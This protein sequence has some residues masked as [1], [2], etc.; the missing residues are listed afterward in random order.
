MGNLKSICTHAVLAVC[1]LLAVLSTVPGQLAE[2]WLVQI[3]VP[4]ASLVSAM[5]AAASAMLA[6]APVQQIC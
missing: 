2:L 5:Y 3:F 4:E 6:W 1:W